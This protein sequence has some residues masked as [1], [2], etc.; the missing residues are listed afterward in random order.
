MCTGKTSAGRLTAQQL[1]CQF[2]DTDEYIEKKYNMSIDQIFENMGEQYFRNIETEIINEVSN[3]DN[4][5]ISCGGG[6][7][8]NKQN[9]RKLRR[10]GI[11]I[12]LKA[13]IDT[14][15]ERL[16][17]NSD[18]KPLAKDKTKAEIAE[19]LKEREKLY[20]QADF[21]ISS[22]GRDVSSVAD[23]I[24]FIYRNSEK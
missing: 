11:I 10:K 7:V 12:C 5:V 21:Y 3:L 18:E 23:E 20:M 1:D 2:L 22:A 15:Y 14:I 16:L 4:T 9:I 13:D 6:C 19:L 8:K 24:E 17:S